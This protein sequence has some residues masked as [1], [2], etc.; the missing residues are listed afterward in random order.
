MGNCLGKTNDLEGKQKDREVSKELDQA[1]IEEANSF[2][3]LLLGSGESGK[4]TVFKQMRII[5]EDG[6]DEQERKEMKKII[7]RNILEIIRSL[8]K[9][10]DNFEMSYDSQEVKNMVEEIQSIP[11]KEITNNVE[12]LM[13][14]ELGENIKNIWEDSAVQQAYSRRNEFQLL[15]SCNYFM[16]E[17]DRISSLDYIPSHQDILR[18][19]TKTEGVKDHI[20]NIEGFKFHFV[21]V[22]GQRSERR[23]WIHVFDNVTAIIFVTAL[24]EY[25]QKL[26]EDNNTNRM[27]ESLL[28][29]DEI[30]NCKYFRDTPIIIFYNK[31]DLFEEKIQSVDLNTC[32]PDYEGGC[33]TQNALE[34]IKKKFRTSD[35]NPSR[36]LYEHTTTATNTEN[37]EVVFNTVKGIFV[38]NEIDMI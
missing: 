3:L 8:I 23:K 22:G 24:S 19:R 30:C 25:D 31:M 2:K 13:S 11:E 4:S 35:K 29:F 28:L 9:A 7:W 18:S 15:D 26:Y 12:K 17:I 27:H 38:L 36:E 21:D 33:D 20:F 14:P 16:K 5:H 1:R 37:I 34:Y 10:V 32:F 6:Y